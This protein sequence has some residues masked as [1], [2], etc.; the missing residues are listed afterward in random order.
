MRK[1]D[2]D[3]FAGFIRYELQF[4]SSLGVCDCGIVIRNGLAVDLLDLSECL[5][6][7]CA[8]DVNCIRS[9]LKGIYQ[10]LMLWA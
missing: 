2:E 10:L 5:A 1:D 8:S 9:Y 4:G 7:L 6:D 3:H